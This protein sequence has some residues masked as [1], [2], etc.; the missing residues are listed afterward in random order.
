MAV[1]S[2]PHRLGAWSLVSE[3]RRRM[4]GP[5]DVGKSTKIGEIE[6]EMEELPP[7]ADSI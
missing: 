2:I 7:L 5:L 3:G 1:I 4:N 6:M